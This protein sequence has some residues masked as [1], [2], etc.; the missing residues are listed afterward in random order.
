MTGK[1]DR[2]V[3]TTRAL[4]VLARMTVLCWLALAALM[5]PAV[6]DDYVL[7]P[8]D[9]I[10]I[11]VYQQPDLS[12][13][14]R[15]AES[16]AVSYPLIGSV[17]LGGLTGAQAERLIATRLRDGGFLQN[18][19]VSVNITQY[20]SQQV[21]VLGAVA[22]PGR[23]PLELS[24]TRLSEM[25]AQAGGI[26]SAVG[27]DVIQLV[28]RRDG[29]P[30]TLQVDVVDLF[31]GAGSVRDEVLRPGDSIFVPR[32]PAYYIYGQVQ[33]PGMYT[34]E[35]GMT[36]AQAI[37]KA[38]GLTARGTDRGVRLQ[39]RNSAGRMDAP[40]EPRLEETVRADDL[41]FLRESLF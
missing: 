21:S 36:L 10:R 2:R 33:R 23:Y 25:L 20:R 28:T 35:R 12:L 27:G 7:G 1:S 38:G 34:I 11:S 18:P 31:G 17:R 6:A 15:I 41:I 40:V 37:A 4:Q 30:V 26:V 24:G 16:G 29:Q 22:R 32:A 39:R 3:R 13:D 5:R 19:Q 14:L 9:V 8:A